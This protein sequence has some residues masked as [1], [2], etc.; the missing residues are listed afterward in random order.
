MKRSPNYRGLHRLGRVGCQAEITPDTVNSQRPQSHATD[1]M[2]QV[3]DSRIAFV[4][5]L[6]DAVVRRRLRLVAFGHRPFF[7]S[8]RED[9]GGTC[10][11][12]FLDLTCGAP[13]GFKDIDSA[14]H[15]YHRSQTRIR[16]TGWHL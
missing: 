12:Y 16:T 9:R 10:I 14:D 7:R 11:D 2:I 5:T 3:I 6:E 1:T 15:I 13:R 8:G 4:A